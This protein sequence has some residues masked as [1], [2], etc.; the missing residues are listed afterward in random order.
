ML[1]QNASLDNGKL[2]AS[3]IYQIL[4]LPPHPFPVSHRLQSNLP[5]KA[6]IIMKRKSSN[7]RDRMDCIEFKSDE[8]K[9]LNETQYLVILKIRSSLMQRNTDMPKGCISSNFNSTT[10]RME[11][12]TTKQS[13]RLKS[14]MKY[15]SKPK[16][17][18]FSKP[19]QVK[20][21]KKMRLPI[22]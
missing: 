11:L 5:N 8:T 22:S 18:I 7:S 6:K 14:D 1:K 4:S 20:R 15:A 19:S 13:K 21:T 12:M 2:C 3:M 9:A 10:S 17:Y 16:Q